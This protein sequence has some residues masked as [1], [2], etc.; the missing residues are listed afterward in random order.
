MNNPEQDRSILQRFPNKRPSPGEVANMMPEKLSR[1]VGS[2]SI[3]AH[4]GIRGLEH[5]GLGAYLSEF[6]MAETVDLAER[7]KAA[8]PEIEWDYDE[9]SNPADNEDMF[10]SRRFSMQWTAFGLA[11]SRECYRLLRNPC[12]E[13]IAELEKLH[14]GFLKKQQRA[15]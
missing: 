4:G 3:Q 8:M 5:H 13:T 12:D 11:V 9:E 6:G 10:Y 14:S 15:R 2:L 1:L 7:R